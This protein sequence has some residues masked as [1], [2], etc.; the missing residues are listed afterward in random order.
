[1]GE[2]TLQTFFQNFEVVMNPKFIKITK[3]SQNWLKSPKFS[4]KI[5]KTPPR[6]LDDRALVRHK[7]GRVFPCV[8]AHGP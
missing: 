3:I 4:E 5:L 2:Q 8:A 6:T 1:M 7:S